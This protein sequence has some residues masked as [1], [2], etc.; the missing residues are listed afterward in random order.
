M[1]LLSPLIL[2]GLDLFCGAGGTTTGIEFAN[3]EGVK[4]AKVIG[5]INHDP[6]AISS[7]SA[8]HPETKHFIEDIRLFD[9][10]LLPKKSVNAKTFLWASLECTNFSN[11]KGGQ[12][13]DADSRTLANHLFRYIEYWK[14]DYILIEN[15]RE[16]MAW[17]PLRVKCSKK[18]NDR[19][20]LAINKDGQYVMIPESRTAGVDYQRWVKKIKDYGYNYDKRLLNAADFGAYT[21]RIRYFGMFAKKGLPMAWP[22]QTH[23]KKP[24]GH[25]KPWKPVKDVLDLNDHGA[26]IFSRKKPLS[27][28][29]LKR[30]YAGLVKYVAEGDE[31]FIKQYNGG[32]NDQ[33]V[34]SN[35]RP[36][37]AI[38]TNNRHAVVTP[39]YIVDYYGNGRTYTGDLPL[40]TILTK[41]KFSFVTPEF[42]QKYHGNGENLVPLNGPASSLTTKDRLAIINAQ[43][44][45][46]QYS[47][48][49]NHQSIDKPSG[50]IVTND[51]H[52]LFSAE[53]PYLLQT[54]FNNNPKSINEP[55]AAI[56]ACRKAQYL[57]NPQFTSKGSSIDNPCFTLIAR[58]DKR[59]PSIVTT[60]HIEY[61]YPAIIVFDEDSEIMKKIKYFMAY[62]GI[63]DIKM[64]MLKIVELKR[65]QGFPDDYVLHGTQA[66]QK[67]FI[68]NAVHSIIPKM[69]V[70]A[71]YSSLSRKMDLS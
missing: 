58:M 11:A 53:Q 63:A 8:N 52:A 38:S 60:E 45:D 67:K 9:T 28:N 19:S 51:K 27:E 16:F 30:I 2:E 64:R 43:W 37:T 71:I 20:D 46:K 70:E 59:P 10:S 12:S 36:I 34:Y 68:G 31:S 7:H 33:R 69:W 13:R 26:S 23:A 21:S 65:I 50:T 39:H 24:I 32:G 44:L 57:V 55:S 35:D 5:C 25:L 41:D 29:T 3:I 54:N 42:L 47:G 15:V 48:E 62:F 61:G 17:G 49:S 6:L 14:P 4:I 22:Q 56:L 1:T 40:G 66:D 18:H